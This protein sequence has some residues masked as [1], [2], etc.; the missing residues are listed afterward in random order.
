M[1]SNEKRGSNG[2]D[3]SP[4]GGKVFSAK[5]RGGSPPKGRCLLAKR[6]GGSPPS[7]L[8]VRLIGSAFLDIKSPEG[9]RGEHP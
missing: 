5:R 2:K 7:H 8:I 9:Q 4:P 6:R 3:L 1:P